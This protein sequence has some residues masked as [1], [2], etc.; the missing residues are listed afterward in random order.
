LPGRDHWGA[1]QTALFA[2]GGVRGGTIIGSSDRNGAYPALSPQ[3]PENLAATI[4]HVLGIP[5]TAQWRDATDRP[6]Q[7][8]FGKPIA[9]LLV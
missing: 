9:G 4:Y 5:E 8:H 1:V 3:T 2:G 6:H 7:V